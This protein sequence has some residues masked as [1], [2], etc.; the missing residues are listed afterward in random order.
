MR[1][2][3][4]S[5]LLVRAASG[6]NAAPTVTAA[7]FHV[8]AAAVGI[9]LLVGLWT[10]IAAA[11]AALTAAWSAF[12]IPAEVGFYI[13]LG[14]LGAALVLLGPGAWSIDARLFGWK[15]VEI[16]SQKRDDSGPV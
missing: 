13:L 10:P 15:R 2:A 12:T 9:L 5:A 3:T 4:G 7:V 16:R 1:V 11:L 8:L 14:T 6:L